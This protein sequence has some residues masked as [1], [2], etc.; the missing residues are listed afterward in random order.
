MADIKV[1]ME[2]IRKEGQER[3]AATGQTICVFADNV[4]ANIAEDIL[5]GM[6]LMTELANKKFD[7][8]TQQREWYNFYNDGLIKFGWTMTGAAH[9]EDA[10]DED[11]LTLAELITKSVTISVS[12]DPRRAAC[13]VRTLAVSPGFEAWFIEHE[14]YYGAREIYPAREDTAERAAFFGRAALDALRQALQARLPAHMVPL[15]FVHMES[16]IFLRGQARQDGKAALRETAQQFEGMFLQ[17]MLKSMREATVKS[18][19]VESSGAETF[20]AMFDKRID[21]VNDK[22]NEAQA[23]AKIEEVQA[24]L[25]KGESFEALA[26]EFS[27]D[28]GSAN[29]GGDL[30]FARTHDCFAAR[31]WAVSRLGDCD[32]GGHWG[33]SGGGPRRVVCF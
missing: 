29:N 19:L 32:S 22:V 12:A 1:E 33:D 13:R 26:K 11:N 17:M 27:Q 28:P 7:K 16:P 3:V 21:E 20:E 23:K 18:D 4:P 6:R 8:E 10:I 2:K 5:A 30:G 14:D 15:A 9:A 31:V 25:A 24:R